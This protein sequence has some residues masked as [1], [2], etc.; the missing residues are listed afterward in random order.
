M[1]VCRHSTSS[2]LITEHL[3]SLQ[4]TRLNRNSKIK[5]EKTFSDSKG[6]NIW[7]LWDSNLRPFRKGHANCK[8]NSWCIMFTLSNPCST[9]CECLLISWSNQGESG[10]SGVSLRWL[11]RAVS[12]LSAYTEFIFIIGS[13][14]YFWKWI[15]LHWIK[16]INSNLINQKVTLIRY[17]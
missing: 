12:Q 6:W 15:W 2:F 5:V 13:H 4:T 10:F 7:R 1:H 11:H 9:F 17:E 3:A 14:L 8:P 16:P